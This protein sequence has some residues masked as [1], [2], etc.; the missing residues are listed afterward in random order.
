ML[1]MMLE[2]QAGFAQGHLQIDPAAAGQAE[3]AAL[4]PSQHIG[5]HGLVID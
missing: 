3:A 1:E 5:D 2:S 4:N